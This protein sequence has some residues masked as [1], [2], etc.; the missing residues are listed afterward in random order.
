LSIIAMIGRCVS[1]PRAS[2]GAPVGVTLLGA[3][4]ALGCAAAVGAGWLLVAAGASV[5]AGGSVG[6]LVAGA[7]AAVGA[8]AA[9]AR[10]LGW[11]PQAANANMPPSSSASR[12]DGFGESIVAPL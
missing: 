2:P 11:P 12:R 6:A 4:V 7:G 10:A 3:D 8:G 9:G 1:A 5:A